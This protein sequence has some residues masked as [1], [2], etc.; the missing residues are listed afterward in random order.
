MKLLLSTLIIIISTLTCVIADD[1][2]EYEME[3]MSVGESLLDYF[4][5][6]NIQKELI[7]EFSYKYKDNKFAQL[8]VGQTNEFPLFKK[9][10]KY[11]ELGITIKPNDEKYIIYGLVGDILCHNNIDKCMEAKDKIINDLKNTFVG[12]KVDSWER[13]HR[14][15]KTG[16]S[17][18]YGNTLIADT[19]DFNFTVNVY[20]MFDDDYNDSVQVSFMSEE[21][22]NFL[23][24]EAYD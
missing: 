1:L 7:S 12:L 19:I 23:L 14:M 8:G 9:L 22:N 10:D 17:I 20:D 6:S 4:S 18:V 3:D 2:N 13:K 15:D 16:R 21:F 5:K 11:D 24:Y